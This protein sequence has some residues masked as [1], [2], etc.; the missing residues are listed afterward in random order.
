MQEEIQINFEDKLKEREERIVNIQKEYPD[1]GILKEGSKVLILN[2]RGNLMW[3]YTG[4]KTITQRKK[5]EGYPNRYS[6]YFRI[7]TEVR[8]D[9]KTWDVNAG[10][11]IRDKFVKI[12]PLP[13]NLDPELMEKLINQKPIFTPKPQSQAASPQKI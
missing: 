1:L 3:V 9:R 7:P 13:K 2:E 6:Y 10:K 5:L 8:K 11:E 4:E 12:N